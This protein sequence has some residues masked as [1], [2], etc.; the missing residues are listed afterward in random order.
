MTRTWL[1]NDVLVVLVTQHVFALAR[2]FCFGAVFG[3]LFLQPGSLFDCSISLL[4]ARDLL[5]T[6]EFFTI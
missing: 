5:Q 2:V 1:E 4:L 6:V 3:I